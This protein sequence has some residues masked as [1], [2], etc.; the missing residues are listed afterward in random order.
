MSLINRATLRV[1]S[2]PTGLKKIVE[3]LKRHK[4]NGPIEI[5]TISPWTN[6]THSFAERDAA[7]KNA[8]AW[9]KNNQDTQK[10]G[11]FGTYHLTVGW[12]S[13]YPETS[14]YI[15][16]SIIDYAKLTGDKDLIERAKRCGDWLISIQK[17]SGGWQSGYVEDN[18]PEVVFNTGQIIRGMCALYLETKEEKYLQSGIK[19]GNWLCEIQNPG[20]YWDKFNY[21]NMVAVYDTYVAAPI[22]ELWAIT[23]DDRYKKAVENHIYWVIKEKQHENGWFAN[24]DNQPHLQAIPLTHTIGYTID[25]ILDCGIILNNQDFINA[26]QKAADAVYAVFNKKKYLAG[27]LNEKWGDGADYICCTG[28]AQISIIWLKLFELT[29]N[30]QYYNAAM[31]MNDFLIFT[32]EKMDNK[33]VFGAQPGSFP[34]WGDYIKFGYPNWATK[35]FIDAMLLEKKH[36]NLIQ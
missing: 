12:S 27:R 23:K 1:V 20:G 21:L 29:K 4:K 33:D 34:I 6:Q 24:C 14:G 10:D 30:I 8:I 32:Q 35:Y 13:S 5:S 28:S 17:P 9:L 36:W 15:I 31:K 22:A 19:A 26:A 16:T 3:D 7:I 18:K 11:G 25:G 2:K